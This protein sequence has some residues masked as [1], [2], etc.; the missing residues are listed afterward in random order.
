MGEL[1]MIICGVW[2]VLLLGYNLLEMVADEQMEHRE[3][4]RKPE[5]KPYVDYGY[6]GKGWF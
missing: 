6:T 3:E 5:I 2:I 4:E 1:I